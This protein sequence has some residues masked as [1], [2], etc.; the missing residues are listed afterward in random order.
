MSAGQ[1]SGEDYQQWQPQ[2]YQQ[3]VE[4]SPTQM[5]PQ[6]TPNWMRMRYSHPTESNKMVEQWNTMTDPPQVQQATHNWTSPQ[7]LGFQDQ[8][9][10]D[11]WTNID[12]GMGWNTGKNPMWQM[13]TMGKNPQMEEKL[14]MIQ[15]GFNKNPKQGMGF[16]GK[17][18]WLGYPEEP[19]V[20][21]YPAIQ[22]YQP[23]TNQDPEEDPSW[24]QREG[25]WGQAQ[26]GTQNP[27]LCKGKDSKDGGS[28]AL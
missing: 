20:P 23:M 12:K 26:K 13:K 19:S 2:E 7:Q 4:W 10:Q 16:K 14:L 17:M 8:R 27:V 6:T 3:Y 22:M 11:P 28:T 5:A 24:K 21:N 25:K 9:N 18:Q 15:E 1:E